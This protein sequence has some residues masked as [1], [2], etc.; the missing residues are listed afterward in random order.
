[1]E[2]YIKKCITFPCNGKRPCTTKWNTL[3][4]SVARSSVGTKK[5]GTPNYGILCGK[6]NNIMVVDCDLLKTK[7]SKAKYL[8][9]VEAWGIICEQFPGLKTMS[10]P[11]VQTKSGGLHLYFKY[12]PE[13]ASGIY[14][15]GS[16]KFICKGAF[17]KDK[18]SHDA[19]LEPLKGKRVMLAD[20]LKKNMKL[21][22]GLIKNL[23]GG[24]YV[25]EGRKFGKV[26]QFKFIWQAG[27]IMV[28]NE[29]DCPKFDSTDNAFMERMLVCPMRSKFKTCEKDDLSS[30]TFKLDPQ[31]DANFEVWRSSLLDLLAKYCRIDGLCQ[32]T[33]PSSM[34]EWK[35]E[36]ISGNNELADWIMDNIEE[37]NNSEDVL[38]LNELKDKYKGIYGPRSISDRD[39]ISIA[40]A[41]FNSKG[42][43]ILERHRLMVNGTRIQKRNAITGIKFLVD[44]SF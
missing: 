42:Y 1:M 17:D 8:C 7:E 2:D 9:G 40:K 25:V 37:T 22:E 35:E 24:R 39:F 5:E 10:V 21:D 20:E 18:D 43:E 32:M 44:L 34:K 19:G 16:T 33:I 26:D 38:S 13:L 41:L 36:I 30:L 4:K 23:A 14:L 31:I 28:F 12:R 6:V 27:I 29:G 3:V 11:T 15:K